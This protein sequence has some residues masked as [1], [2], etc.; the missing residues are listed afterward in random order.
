VNTVKTDS[1]T[2]RRS[3]SEYLL[4]NYEVIISVNA[5]NIDFVIMSEKLQ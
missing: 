2:I 4:N 3:C 1:V 5:V